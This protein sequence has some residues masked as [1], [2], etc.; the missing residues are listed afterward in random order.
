M[1]KREWL[2][3]KRTNQKL[4]QEEVAIRSNIKRPYY[5]QIELGLRSPSVKVAKQI[6]EVIGFDWK[7]FFEKDCSDLKQKNNTF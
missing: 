7:I 2:Y 4:T 5:S 1:T 3:R 6:A